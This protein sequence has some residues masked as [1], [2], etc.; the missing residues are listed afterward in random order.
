MT[1]RRGIVAAFVRNPVLANLLA[2]G[3][4]AAGFLAAQRLPRET[5]P[6]T[7][8]NYLYITTIYPGAGPSEVE[9]TVTSR[10]EQ[11]IEGIPAIWEVSSTSE[12]NRSL[13]G[14]F[15]DPKVTATAEVLRLVQARVSAIADFPPGVRRPIVEEGI[16]RNAVMTLG[17][18]GDAPEKTLRQFAIQIR[19]DLI[20]LPQVSQVSVFGVRETEIAIQVDPL[21]M[22]EFGLSLGQIMD[23]V[24]AGTLDAPAGMLRSRGEE[25]SV[26][27]FSGRQGAADFVDLVVHARPDGTRILLGDI[28]QVRDDFEPSPI[29][30]RING[31]PGVTIQVN[32]TP[33]EDISTVASAVRGFVSRMASSLPDGVQLIVL[34]DRSLDVDERVNMLIGN[35]IMGIVLLLICLLLF[36]DFRAAIGVAFGL[37]VAMAGALAVMYWT[38]QTLNLISLFGIIMADAIVLDDS[39]IIADAVLAKERAGLP[40]QRAAIEGA[41]KVTRPVLYA[42]L[43]TTIMF[44]PLMFVEGAMGKLIYVLPVVVIASI[45][46]S[47]GEAFFILPAH[48][49]EWKRNR[50]PNGLVTAEPDALPDQTPSG[51]ALRPRRKGRTRAVLD[52]WIEAGITRGYR[53]LIAMLIRNRLIVLAGSAASIMICI[54]LVLGGRTPFVL[55]PKLD[56]NTVR[57]RVRFSEG[58]PIGTAEAAVR[59]LEAAAAALNLDAALRPAQPGPLVRHIHSAVGAWVDYLPRPGSGLCETTLELMPAED[60]RIDVTRILERWRDLIGDIPHAEAITL[61][62]EELGPGDKPL[63]IQLLGDELQVLRAAAD[64][65][66]ARLSEFVGVFDVVDD[67]LPGKRE[68]LVRL[69]PEAGS[70]GLTVA[71][72]SR[73]LRGALH[74]GEAAQIETPE[75]STRVVVSLEERRKESPGALETMWIRTPLGTSVPL[76]Q[77][78]DTSM[79]RGFAA[80]GRKDGHR[81][82]RIQAD[83]DEHHTNAE[84][85]LQELEASYLDGLEQRFPGITYRIDG[86][87]KRIAESL[88]SLWKA[89][90]V[91]L[92]VTYI[93]LG[94]AL[95][96][97]L[98]PLILMAAV[99]LGL[100]G[101]IVGHYVLGYELSLMSVFG[102]TS[103]AGIVVNDALV[104]LDEVHRNLKAGMGVREAVQRGSESRVIAVFLTAITNVA[105]MS[106]LLLERSTQAVPLIP[107]AISVVF[108]LCFAMALTLLVVPAAYVAVND[109]RRFVHWLRHGGLYPAAEHVEP[110]L[111]HAAT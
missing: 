92:I 90:L 15:F 97:Y 99:P 52:R 17:L 36:M 26:R 35:G 32:K 72:I 31:K 20:A 55:F 94:A 89:A 16:L 8:V 5:F 98:E 43:T 73:Q 83:V 77:V 37:P 103:V 81:R 101:A 66:Q 44:V 57:A 13:V 30:A 61:S 9:R 11:A 74:G 79:T 84:N 12:E 47:L 95:K 58:T 28:A 48:L 53:P 46:A 109:L 19:D 22:E 25:I 100:G 75:G 93:V 82:V 45:A 2:L 3:T 33:A 41:R 21:R 71:D 107:I 104:L 86:Q 70:L 63:E 1:S 111:A 110:R 51:T 24:A 108:G 56:C 64:D 69:K 88:E 49:Y 6:E 7:A 10:I 96:S 78:A 76:T 59:Q 65:L 68:L 62:R 87:R 14:A 4:I 91:A 40:A 39:I 106:P 50:K 67:L 34:A 42:S 27:T 18:S 29:S 60:R 102:M 80:I 105:G 85:V 38:G 23:A 54:G